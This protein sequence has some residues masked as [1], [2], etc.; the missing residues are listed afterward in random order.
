M[1][2]NGEMLDELLEEIRAVLDRHAFVTS[3]DGAKW[4][5]ECIGDLSLPGENSWQYCRMNSLRD[6]YETFMR[7]TGR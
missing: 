3:K 2:A 5:E 6:T 7:V 4:C 1:S